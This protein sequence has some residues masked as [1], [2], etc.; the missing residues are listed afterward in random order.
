MESD[1]HTTHVSNRQYTKW[2][3]ERAVLKGRILAEG[4][5]KSMEERGEAVSRYLELTRLLNKAYS[6]GT[7]V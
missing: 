6:S 5:F 2:F 1:A 7:P 3:K 4:S